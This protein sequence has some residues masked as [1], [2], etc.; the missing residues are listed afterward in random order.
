MAEY[1][2]GMVALVP[3]QADLKRLAVD[4]G[5]APDQLHLTLAYL[6]DDVT[7]WPQENVD[8]LHAEVRDLLSG[9]PIE[10]RVMG[11]AMF[12]PDGG[13]DGDRE[14]CMVYLVGDTDRISP[15]RNHLAGL[16]ENKINVPSQ[17]EPFLPHITGGYGLDPEALSYTGPVT[18]DHV[19]VAMGDDITDYPLTEQ[20]NAMPEEIT[21]AEDANGYNANLVN[22]SPGIPVRFPVLAV[23]GLSTSDGRYIEPG[24]LGTRPLPLPI[25]AQT[26]TPVGGGG[27]DGAQ[28]IGRL[29]TARRVPGP[30][31]VSKITGKP[32]PEGTFIW[33]G[34]GHIDP[35]AP[36]AN[37]ARKGYLT[38]NS[39]DLSEIE[40]FLEQDPDAPIEEPDALD[41]V[42]IGRS[43]ERMRLTKGV[44]AATTLVPIP[45][46]ADA[47][48]ELDGHQIMAAEGLA[49]AAMPSWRSAELGDDT[50]LPCA[51]ESHTSVDDSWT[52][53]RAV[54][55]SA[56]GGTLPSISWFRDPGLPGPTPLTIDDDGRVYGHLAAWNTCHTSFA[57]KCVLAPKSTCDYAY[58][59][60]GAKRVL[61]EDGDVVQVGIGK[62]TVVLDADEDGHAAMAMDAMPAAAHYDNAAT[63][64]ADVEIGEDS[65]GIWVAGAVRPNATREQIDALMASTLSGDWRPINGR[66]ELVAALGVNIGGFPVPRARVASGTVVAL[67]AAGA[68][69]RPALAVATSEDKLADKI[70]DRVVR[71]LGV[72]IPKINEEDD[73]TSDLAAR[74]AAVLAALTDAEL[75]ERRDTAFAPLRDET[76]WD[77]AIEA[78]DLLL[79]FHDDHPW[80]SETLTAAGKKLHLPPFI[81]RIEKHL[82]RKGMT[83]SHAIATAVNAAKKMCATGDLNF[84]GHQNVNPGSRAD[85]CAAVAQWKKDRPGAR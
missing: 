62:L 61:D 82:R 65:H 23:E 24:A 74:R 42:K 63:A 14:P 57:G 21:T 7:R 48:V 6:G 68:I 69:P 29:D 85:A 32:F 35:D 55:A 50:C 18:F 36:A 66:L 60:T 25:L 11:H 56:D 76:E 77:L 38:G 10:A 78:A 70:A 80:F 44:I 13:P 12:N 3:S 30:S 37:L 67:V 40:A 58:F 81:K 15:M 49:A 83:E 51:V 84:P 19:R 71:Q 64:V 1:K 34:T 4:G 73:S 8:A 31:V 22:D 28:V 53:D 2:S 27:H 17:H 75:T 39:V 54:V 26:E 41:G 45:A 46:F 33:E 9:G 43:S 47:Y 16:M 5:D 20:E 72:R 52:W 79:S 59:R